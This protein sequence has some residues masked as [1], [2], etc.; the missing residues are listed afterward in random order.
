MTSLFSVAVADV[1]RDEQHRSW[2]IPVEWLRTAL[3][4]S[5]ASPT[6]KAGRF[7]VS[8]LKNEGRFLVRGRIEAQI[9]LPCA[10]TLDPAVYDLTPEL[11]L[12]L[13]REAPA[14]PHAPRRRARARTEDA[15]QES[16]LSEEDAASD[17]FSGDLIPLDEFVREQV[18]LELPMFPLRSDLRFAPP[19]AIGAPPQGSA[20]GHAVDPRLKPLGKLANELRSREGSA[21]AATTTKTRT[22]K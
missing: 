17:S 5:E 9:Q 1:E 20:V 21:S 13:R 19:A 15:P 11:F 4:G 22:K 7:S 12:M 14:S 3:E 18:L 10:R 6:G 8:V 2:E 16:D